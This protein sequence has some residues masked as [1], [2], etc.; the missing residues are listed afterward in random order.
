MDKN[1]EVFIHFRALSFDEEFL[2]FVFFCSF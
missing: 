2:F 1:V